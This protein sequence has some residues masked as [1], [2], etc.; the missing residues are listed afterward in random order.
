MYKV[1]K[2]KGNNVNIVLE[3]VE[4]KAS[5]V[6]GRMSSPILDILKDAGYKFDD[7]SSM[8]IKDEWNLEV[9]EDV[10]KELAKQAMKMSKPI[11]DQ[12]KKAKDVIKKPN[13]Q[14][15]AMDVLLGL[16]SYN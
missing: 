10:G 4:T 9:N 8:S 16:A 12:S 13:K 14:I 1:L 7:A 3:N 2:E 5:I 11:R 6:L 15:D